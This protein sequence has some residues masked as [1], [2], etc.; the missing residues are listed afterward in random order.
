MRSARSNIEGQVGNV[1]FSVRTGAGSIDL[2]KRN[3]RDPFSL[4]LTTFEGIA[5]EL[6][7]KGLISV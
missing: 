6:Q 1:L 3:E 5:R 7:Q 2:T 4:A